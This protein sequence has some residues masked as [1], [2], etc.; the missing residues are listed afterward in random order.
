MTGTPETTPLPI[1]PVNAAQHLVD[2]QEIAL[3]AA[4]TRHSANTKRA[5]MSDWNRFTQWGAR[6]GLQVLPATEETVMLYVADLSTQMKPDGEWRYKASSVSR[7]VVSINAIHREAGHVAPVGDAVNRVLTGLRR[8]RQ[9]QVARKTPILLDELRRIITSMGHHRWPTGVAAARDTLVM[10]LGFATA[11]RRS[12]IGRLKVGDI[13]FDGPHLNVLIRASKTD[14][15]GRGAILAVPVGSNPI[16]CGP[17][18]WIHWLRLRYA[19]DRVEQMRHVF[20]RGRPHSW[21]HL[22]ANP[23]ALDGISADPEH[24]AIVS[25]TRA[26][27][28]GNG[29]LSGNSLNQIVKRHIADIGKNPD[30]YGFHSLRAGFV[31]QARRNG[32]STRAVRRQTGHSSDSMVDIYDRDFAPLIGNAVTELGL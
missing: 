32:A 25:V 22:C 24:P 16:T 4:A 26:G 17:C 23:D 18:A 20:N 11:A 6:V 30:E 8:A 15:E 19:E 12:D 28:L 2:L 1:T 3:Q 7:A 29:H 9:E 5:Y 13:T 21:E 31:T 27:G 14:Q 10:I